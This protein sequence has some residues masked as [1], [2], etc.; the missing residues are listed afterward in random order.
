MRT[1]RDWRTPVVFLGV[2]LLLGFSWL[3][4]GVALTIRTRRSLQIHMMKYGILEVFAQTCT[5]HHYSFHDKKVKGKTVTVKG[6]EDINVL[7]KPKILT[8]NNSS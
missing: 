6:I 1:S 8:A 3:V 7:C 4:L 2:S 5:F